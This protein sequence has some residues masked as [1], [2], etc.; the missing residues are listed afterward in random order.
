MRH[1]SYLV[2]AVLIVVFAMVP[3]RAYG[4]TPNGTDINQAISIYFG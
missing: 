2:A 3:M 1:R 4:Q